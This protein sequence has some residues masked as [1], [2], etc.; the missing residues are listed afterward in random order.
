MDQV[1]G[2]SQAASFLVLALDHVAGQLWTRPVPV[3]ASVRD[4]DTLQK[5]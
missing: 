4:I 3:P 1:S 2:G 5:C